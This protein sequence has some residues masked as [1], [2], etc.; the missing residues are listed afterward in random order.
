MEVL[1]PF[2]DQNKFWKFSKFVTAKINNSNLTL[3]HTI[4]GVTVFVLII[5]NWPCTSCLSDF[6]ITQAITP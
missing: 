4:H 2:F 6:E 1:L 3:C 5:S